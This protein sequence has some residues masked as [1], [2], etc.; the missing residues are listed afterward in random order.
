MVAQYVSEKLIEVEEK[1]SKAAKEALTRAL[2]LKAEAEE[3]STQDSMAPAA[4]RPVLEAEEQHNVVVQN[5]IF[6]LAF[7]FLTSSHICP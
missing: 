6:P 1:A 5:L 4:P 2:K 7:F 3:S